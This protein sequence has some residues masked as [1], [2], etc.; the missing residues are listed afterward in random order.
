MIEALP[1]LAK[2]CRDIEPY[3]DT[4]PDMPRHDREKLCHDLGHL[5]YPQTVSRHGPRFIARASRPFKH[6]CRACLESLS[7]LARRHATLSRRDQVLKI[8]VVTENRNSL[9]RQRTRIL[10]RDREPEM[11]SSPFFLP[12]SRFYFSSIHFI[13]YYCFCTTCTDSISLGNCPHHTKP[14]RN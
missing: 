2:L 1:F 5:A 12:S 7:P 8:S 11:G 6:S 4:G 14:V 3:R 9:S 13:K 10:C